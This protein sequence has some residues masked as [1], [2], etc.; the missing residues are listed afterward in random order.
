MCT[1]T[2]HCGAQL[3]FAAGFFWDQ[4]F[5]WKVVMCR[6][7]KVYMAA[8]DPYCRT[9]KHDF[10]AARIAYQEVDISSNEAA[11]KELLGLYEKGPLPVI[12]ED[13]MVVPVSQVMLNARVNF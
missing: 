3:N 10:D 5:L 4:A 9:I 13:G 11:F 2:G 12:V 8:C 7:R 1:G 6:E